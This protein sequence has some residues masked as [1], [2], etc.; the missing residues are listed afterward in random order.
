MAKVA[1]DVDSYIASAPE[2]AR[3]KLVEL[4]RIIRGA[5]PQAEEVISYRMPYYRYHGQ[6]VGFAAFKDHVGIFGLIPPGF[7]KELAPYKTGRG[8]I[9]F[10]FGKPLP[11][12]LIAKIVKAHMKMNEGRRETAKARL[13]AVG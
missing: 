3:P 7:K 13:K 9:Q 5:A 12:R 4:R 1:K 6:L 2:T 8:S 11:A 10:P